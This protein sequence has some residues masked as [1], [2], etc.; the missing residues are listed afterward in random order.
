[1]KMQVINLLSLDKEA[2]VGTRDKPTMAPPSEDFSSLLEKIVLEGKGLGENSSEPPVAKDALVEALVKQLEKEIAKIL[3]NV[4]YLPNSLTFILANFEHAN[5][6]KLSAQPEMTVTTGKNFNQ[7]A[8]ELSKLI[9]HLK[10]VSLNFP[11]SMF[12]VLEKV[13][14]TAEKD[15]KDAITSGKLPEGNF[16]LQKIGKILALADKIDINSSADEQVSL[17][18]DQAMKKGLLR[19][20]I[21]QQFNQDMFQLP[22]EQP[23]SKSVLKPTVTEASVINMLVLLL[24]KL[25][26]INEKVA[27]FLPNQPKDISFNFRGNNQNLELISQL[28]NLGELAINQKHSPDAQPQI[29]KHPGIQGEFDNFQLKDQLLKQVK[30]LIR[31]GKS[32]ISFQLE[33]KELGRLSLKINLESGIITAQFTAANLHVKNLIEASLANLRQSLEDLG[34]KETRLE[35]G[36]GQHFFGEGSQRQPKAGQAYGNKKH[37]LNRVTS[38]GYNDGVSLP[39]TNLVRYGSTFEYLI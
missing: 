26:T 19:S 6:E 10:K 21:L 23:D 30:L 38:Q 29:T 9:S 22:G 34:H 14:F 3:D 16:V 5:F 7:F 4:N 13:N 24:Q 39:G 18:S 17:T 15:K 35:V 27:S 28:S 2:S 37:L 31:E 32:Q 25:K 11:C 1:M 33:P 8:E 36:V 12:P 20:Q